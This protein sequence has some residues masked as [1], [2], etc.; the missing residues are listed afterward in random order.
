[1]FLWSMNPTMNEA[2]VIETLSLPVG[3]RARHGVLRAD[4]FVVM[5]D[6]QACARR[7]LEQA[8]DEADGLLGQAREQAQEHLRQE[9]RRIAE[10]ATLLLTG[11]RGM[12]EVMLEEAGRLAVEL[13]AQ[14]FDRLMLETT[15]Q[16]RLQAAWHRVRE[17]APSKLLSAVAWLHPEDAALAP[18]MPWEIKADPRLE[19]GTCRLEAANGEWRAGFALAADALRAALADFAAI[20]AAAVDEAEQEPPQPRSNTDEEES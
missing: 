9:Q 17:E 1:M 12:Q 6:A 3:L 5:D 2:F 19:R 14:V 10:E 8:R 7:L 4:A 15:P 16:E 13:A 18:E 11:L 20:P